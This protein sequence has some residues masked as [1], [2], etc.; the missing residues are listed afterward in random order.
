MEKIVLLILILGIG[1]YVSTIHQLK[2]QNSELDDDEFDLSVPSYAPKVK[3]GNYKVKLTA[4]GTHEEATLKTINRYANNLVTD[5]QLDM[6]IANQVDIYTAEDI[7]YELNYIGA[8]G[9][10]LEEK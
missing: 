5:I 9:E 3:E 8:D 7:V 1:G 4:I 2:K 10:I 6:I